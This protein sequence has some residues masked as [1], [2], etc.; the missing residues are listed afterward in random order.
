MST[1][2]QS[3]LEQVKSL[4]TEQKQDLRDELDILLALDDEEI[5]DAWLDVARTRLGELREG[6]ATTVSIEEVIESLKSTD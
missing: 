1:V 2:P 6:S 4:T 3:L 5:Q